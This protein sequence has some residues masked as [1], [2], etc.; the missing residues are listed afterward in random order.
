MGLF[1]CKQRAHKRGASVELIFLQLKWGDASI[2]TGAFHGGDCD[3]DG[4][5]C[6][7]TRG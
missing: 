4:A 5:A 6:C 3:S 7:K 1:G 2:G